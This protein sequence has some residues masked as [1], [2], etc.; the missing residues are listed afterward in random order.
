METGKTRKG[1]MCG[2][3]LLGRY[4][5]YDKILGCELPSESSLVPS[6]VGGAE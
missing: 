4:S 5:L 6:G 2:I 3:S 1:G